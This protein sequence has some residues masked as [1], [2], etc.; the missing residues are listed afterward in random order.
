M[1]YKT[2][3]GFHSALERISFILLLWLT[4][5]RLSGFGVQLEVVS[6]IAG[7]AV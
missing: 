4:Q 1:Q 5:L 2:Q 7:G 3:K 6:F